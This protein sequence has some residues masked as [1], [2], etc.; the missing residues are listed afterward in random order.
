MNHHYKITSISLASL[1]LA[2]PPI[3][4]SQ[5]RGDGKQSIGE[6][7]RERRNR[8]SLCSAIYIYC[9]VTC[10]GSVQEGGAR[11]VLE[12]WVL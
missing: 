8:A 3:E 10:G 1:T 7:Q 6:V 9:A 5:E 12:G 2:T 4:R 11:V